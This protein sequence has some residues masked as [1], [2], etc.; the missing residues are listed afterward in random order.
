ME[1]FRRFAFVGWI[2]VPTLLLSIGGCGGDPPPT[3][4]EVKD[5]SVEQMEEEL[6]SG[7]ELGTEVE[8]STESADE[9]TS[10]SGE[11]DTE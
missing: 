10:N 6:E 9:E 1:K 11:T 2:V 8:T 4:E 3:P 7:Y 5:T